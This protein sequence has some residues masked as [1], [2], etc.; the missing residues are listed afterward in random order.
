MRDQADTNKT[1]VRW[2]LCELCH[3]VAHDPEGWDESCDNCAGHGG[4]WVNE[5]GEPVSVE[6]HN[7]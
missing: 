6:D 7:G 2:Q 1:T 3:G 5:N 4:K